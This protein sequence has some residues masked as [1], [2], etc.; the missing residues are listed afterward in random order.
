M[1][2]KSLDT[3]TRFDIESLGIA[4]EYAARLH[5]SLTEIIGV[6]GTGTPATW[7]YIT[8][9]ILNPQLPFSFHQMLYYG[10]YKDYGPDPPAWL[11]DSYALNLV[12]RF[13]CLC[14]ISSS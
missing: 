8:K 11:P 10:C 12:I 14:W 3:I 1:A 5:E 13:H 9:R 7:H 4:A 2:Y 6:H